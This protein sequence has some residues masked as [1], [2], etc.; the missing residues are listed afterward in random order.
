MTYKFHAEAE[1]DL[2]S[3]VEFYSAI[4]SRLGLKFAA[5]VH[6]CIGRILQSPNAWPIF[7]RQ[8]R[9]SLLHRFPYAVIYVIHNKVVVVVAIS[10]TRRN[11]TYWINRLD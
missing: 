6:D 10:H 4:E 2:V 8:A 7:H 5:E 3:A 11:E 1:A 9:R